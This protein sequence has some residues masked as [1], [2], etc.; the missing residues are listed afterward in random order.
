MLCRFVTPWALDTTQTI[1]GQGANFTNKLTAKLQTARP[2]G[3]NDTLESPQV[4][5]NTCSTF[6]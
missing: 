5:H 3:S 1:L 6:F 4:T 2:V